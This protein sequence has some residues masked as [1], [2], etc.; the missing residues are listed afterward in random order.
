[1]EELTIIDLSADD[2]RELTERIQHGL[3]GIHHLVIRAYQGRAWIAMGYASW[4]AYCDGELAGAR[5]ALPRDERREL[6]GE[7][8]DAGMSTRAIGAAVGVSPSTVHSDLGAPVQNRTREMSDSPLDNE[9]LFREPVAASP[10]T[11]TDG[12]TYAPRPQ[13]Q[14]QRSSEPAW[15]ADEQAMRAAVERG[16]VVVASLREPHARLVAWAASVGK[17]ER[18][19]RKSPWGNPFEIPDDGD[20]NTVIT[21][22]ADHY[23]PH[24][25][26]LRAKLEDL[27]GKVLG[28][29]CAPLPCHGDVLKFEAE[30]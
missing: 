14:P 28:C 8:R 4:D 5:P 19:D 20:R 12:K 9:A 30:Q 24:K 13:S 26:T 6:V 27:R 7:L 3:R 1:M 23:L 2:A 15:S 25:P 21:K 11:G 10:V 29:W 17:Y 22:Y 18:I 16:E